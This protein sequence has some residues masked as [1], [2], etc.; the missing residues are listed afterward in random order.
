[1]Q[2][3]NVSK[4]EIFQH[5]GDV[6]DTIIRLRDAMRASDQAE[7]ENQLGNLDLCAENLRRSLGYMGEQQNQLYAF[8]AS[9][10]RS[11]ALNEEAISRR[12]DADVAELSVDY[13]SQMA[14]FQTVLKAAGQLVRPSLMDFL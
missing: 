10:Q 1:M 7:I 4:A 13:N 5:A 3:R 2:M 6:F 12:R 11:V 8:R 14:L 9:L